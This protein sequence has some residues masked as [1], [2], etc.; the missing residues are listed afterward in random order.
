M[1]R[2]P[3]NMLVAAVCVLAGGAAGWLARTPQ[4][5]PVKPADDPAL[6]SKFLD[7]ADK[8]FGT[9]GDSNLAAALLAA[10]LGSD[11]ADSRALKMLE[12]TLRKRLEIALGASHWDEAQ[13]Q[14]AAFHLAT[15]NALSECGSVADVKEL[16]QRQK[17]AD[18]WATEVESKRIAWLAEKITRLKTSMDALSGPPSWKQCVVFET[19][20]GSIQNVPT[21]DLLAQV[22]ALEHKLLELQRQ[23][24]SVELGKLTSDD[25]DSLQDIYGRLASAAPQR[26]QAAEPDSIGAQECS[27]WQTLGTAVAERLRL[28]LTKQEQAKVDG[29]N[30]VLMQQAKAMIAAAQAKEPRADCTWQSVLK[31]LAEA[32]KCLDQIE[33]GC[34]EGF[35]AQVRTL[36]EA[37]SSMAINARTKQQKVYNLWALDQIKGVRQAVEG[38]QKLIEVMMPLAEIDIPLLHSE[39][40][41]LYHEVYSKAYRK[42]NDD[43]KLV[44][45]T[46]F[47]NTQRKTYSDK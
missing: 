39:L 1:P 22:D 9:D 31:D 47:V 27:K 7:E 36:G 45:V 13:A 17:V 40:Q 34:S 24:L 4:E 20:L 19:A 2:F 6:T 25:V 42:L 16:L 28:A 12:S 38:G 21:T 3:W 41:G 43:E 35:I 32:Q 44:L 26:G 5:T 23:A 30:F 10:A 8:Q 37:I 46:Q 33:T 15:S 18:D 29:R 11:P 14:A